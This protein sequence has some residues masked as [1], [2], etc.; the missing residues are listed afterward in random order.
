MGWD[1]G[2]ITYAGAKT[3]ITKADRI[4]SAEKAVQVIESALE[5]YPNEVTLLQSEDLLREMVVSIKVS[6]WVEKAEKA[7]LRGNLELG[8]SLYRDALHYLGRENMQSQ[9]RDLAAQQINAEIEKIRL[10]ENGNS[11]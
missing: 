6:Y 8:K 10:L 4:K 2:Q 1:R 7:V 11:Y 5:S 9:D 3:G